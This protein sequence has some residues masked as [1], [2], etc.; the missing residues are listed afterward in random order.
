[1]LVECLALL[2]RELVELSDENAV[3]DDFF[4]HCLEESHC[5]E[6]LAE[7]LTMQF[8][9]TRDLLGIRVSLFKHV[10]VSP[11]SIRTSTEEEGDSDDAGDCIEE[12]RFSKR[13]DRSD[14]YDNQHFFRVAFELEFRCENRAK[15][16][17]EPDYFSVHFLAA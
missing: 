11:R 6:F 4:Q 13:G 16:H 8:L 1:M 17:R 9:S 14:E 7:L 15:I 12:Y 5:F 3:R 10:Y 2:P